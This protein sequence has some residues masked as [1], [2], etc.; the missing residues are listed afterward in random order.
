VH[1]VTIIPRGPALGL[2]QQL[3]KTDRLSMSKQFAKARIAVLMGGRVAEDIVFGH[4]T[5]GASND[6]KQASDIARRM[7]TEFGM[8]DAVGPVNYGENDDA[9]FLGRDFNQSGRTYSEKTAQIIDEEVQQLVREGEKTARELLSGQ[10]ELL[11][12]MAEA[13][14]ERETLDREEIDAIVEGRDLPDRKKLF[15]PTY[16]ERA[17]KQKEKRRA[18]SIFG[19]PKPVPSA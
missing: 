10:R 1:K 13:L 19:Q 2:T 14:L 6:I 5:T 18:A 17:E 11:D 8:S 7:V 4:F 16:R 12:K 3:P 9:V 15:I